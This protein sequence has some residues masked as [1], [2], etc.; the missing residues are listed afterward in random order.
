MDMPRPVP[1]ICRVAA[2]RTRSK[3]RNILPRNSWLM[4]MPLSWQEKSSHTRPSGPG[5]WEKRTWISPPSWVYFTALPM[6]FTR[7]CRRRRE[8]PTSSSAVTSAIW[9]WRACFFRSAWGR[10]MTATSWTRSARESSSSL[11]VILPLSMRDMS[12][13]S[14]TRLIRWEEAV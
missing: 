3:G 11:R 12:S 13:T 4:P 1:S 14:F 10:T 9:M 6:M 7:I 8:S 5:R 2:L